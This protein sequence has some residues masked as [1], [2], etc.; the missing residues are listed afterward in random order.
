MGRVQ[1][2]STAKPAL[3]ALVA[4]VVLLAAGSAVAQQQTFHLDRLEVPGAPDDGAVL[5]RPVTQPHAIF[6]A[7]LGLGL[8]FDPLRTSNITND[9][10]ALRDQKFAGRVVLVGDE[11]HRPYH[12][13]PLSKSFLL[14]DTDEPSLAMRPDAYYAEKQ[15]ELMSSTRAVAIDRTHRKLALDNGSVVDFEHLVLAVGARNRPLPVP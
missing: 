6:Y 2:R 10:S 7:Q 13:P 11:P 5:F 3:F 8:S 15:I 14:A 4:S 1:H 12:R 9:A